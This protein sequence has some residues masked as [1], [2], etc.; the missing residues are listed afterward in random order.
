VR[1]DCITIALGL[2]EV[3]VIREKETEEEIKVEVEYRARSAICPRCGQK[4]P[5][6]H[7]SQSEG[8]PSRTR[9]TGGYG[10]SPCSLPFISGAS[11]A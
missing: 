7:P 4:T 1:D 10:T 8:P 2:P 9:G 3:R 11:A 6:V 5:K